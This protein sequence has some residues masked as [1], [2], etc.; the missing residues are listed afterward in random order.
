MHLIRVPYTLSDDRITQNY[1]A[2]SHITGNLKQDFT[3]TKKSRFS[4]GRKLD[5]YFESR[6][7]KILNHASRK[8]R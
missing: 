1:L 4:R 8:I 2:F 7:S 3:F 6:K 5:L